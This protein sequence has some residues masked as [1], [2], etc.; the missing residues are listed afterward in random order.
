MM[1]M[2]MFGASYT[3]VFF[4][5][6]CITRVLMFSHSPLFPVWDV[7]KEEIWFCRVFIRNLIKNK[8]F[9]LMLVKKS[10]ICVNPVWF[11]FFIVTNIPCSNIVIIWVYAR[12]YIHITVWF[13]FFSLPLHAHKHAVFVEQT[14]HGNLQVREKKINREREMW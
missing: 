14:E 5:Y 12:A 1:M 8:K 13:L 4:M 10:Q 2:I 6:E 9:L 3:K 7:L 11:S